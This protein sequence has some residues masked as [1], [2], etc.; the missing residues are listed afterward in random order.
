[1]AAT[2]SSPHRAAHRRVR[3]GLT[4]VA[5]LAALATL[6]GCSGGA[7]APRVTITVPPTEAAPSD[8]PPEPAQPQPADPGDSGAPANP[9]TYI[10]DGLVVTQGDVA[11]ACTH[12]VCHYLHVAWSG[13]Q[14]GWHSVQC[15]SDLASVGAWSE[16]N[17]EFAATVGERDIGCFLAY[18]GSHVWII[19]DGEIESPHAYWP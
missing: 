1:M 12:S 14:K 13:L 15:V 7:T 10:D 5:A 17:Y 11:P 16:G 6:T 19:I 9:I 18:P 4:A 8:T 2:I 3:V